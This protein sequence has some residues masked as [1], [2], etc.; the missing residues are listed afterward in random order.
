MEDDV[1]ANMKFIPETC[2]RF[3]ELQLRS[4]LRIMN[5]G[6]SKEKANIFCNLIKSINKL[7]LDLLPNPHLL[8]APSEHL[9]KERKELLDQLVSTVIM[10]NRCGAFQKLD[11]SKT[12]LETLNLSNLDGN[13]LVLDLSGSDFTNSNLEFVTF[14]ETVIHEAIFLHAI[15]PAFDMPSEESKLNK[16]NCLVS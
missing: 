5:E 9:T 10:L 15:M 2:P 7:N 14:G 6:G 8:M 1:R 13:G 16:E 12:D 3:R 4:I 11:L